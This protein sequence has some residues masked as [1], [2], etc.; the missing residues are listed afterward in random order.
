MPSFSF[1]ATCLV[2]FAAVPVI[3]NPTGSRDVKPNGDIVTLDT[4][5]VTRNGARK[6]RRDG[7]GSSTFDLCKKAPNC[8]IYDHP[9]L[10]KSIRFVA[11]MEPGSEHY[12]ATVLGK[13]EKPTKDGKGKTIDRRN[14]ED[15]SNIDAGLDVIN[16]G[17][18]QPQVV[19]NNL[20]NPCQ[21]AMC[22]SSPQFYRTT[23]VRD[24][25]WWEGGSAP[26]ELN[27][28]FTATGQYDGYDARNIFIESIKTMSEKGQSWTN[29]HWFNREWNG[30]Y[31]LEDSGDQ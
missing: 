11:G 30:E 21:Q 8:E 12:N 1:L 9:L 2:A 16:W 17:N 26:E 24:R 28:R 18:V 19:M 4:G 10:G 25:N 3:G 14:Q 13:E 7:L 31:W 23:A 29:Q 6:P 5:V 15:H 22:D 27:I 20:Y